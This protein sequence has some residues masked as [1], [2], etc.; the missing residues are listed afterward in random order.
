[1][2]P[3]IS[4]TT[5][6]NASNSSTALQEMHNTA[7]INANNTT[8]NTNI[9]ATN[10]DTSIKLWKPQTKTPEWEIINK[11]VEKA[12]TCLNIMKNLNGMYAD[13]QN[14]TKQDVFDFWR[15]TLY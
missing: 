5:P 13:R 6:F 15:Y 8:A 4:P 1:M 2:L 12:V 11:F 3:T 7:N 14:Y 9:A 10:T